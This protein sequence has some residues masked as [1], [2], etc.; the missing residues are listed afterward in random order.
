[1][2]LEIQ[3]G[4]AVTG[5]QRFNRPELQQRLMRLLLS[6]GGIKMFGLR[7]ISKSTLRLYVMEQLQQQGKSF[8]FIDA[9]GLHSIEDLIAELFHALPND[10]NLTTKVFKLIAD[11]SPIKKVME[12]LA[13]GTKTGDVMVAAYWKEAYNSIRDALKTCPV[14]PMLI[15]DEFPFLLKNMLN[16]NAEAKRD[17][18]NQL[19][20]AMREWRG[21]GMKMLLTG[22]IG[23]TALA[24]QYGLDRDH[25]NDLLPF[26]VPELTEAEARDFI[27]QATDYPDNQWTEAH[28]TEFIKQSS[29]LYPS[30]LVKG[31]LEIGVVNP[32]APEAFAEIFAC[33][34]RP[35]LHEDFYQQFNKRFKLY[36]EIDKTMQRHIVV[37]VLKQII[38]ASTAIQLGGLEYPEGY[39]SVELAE[40]LDMLVEDGFIRFIED[41]DGHR[42][43]LPASRLAK[44]WW[45]RARLA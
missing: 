5:A 1:M 35:V 38:G 15:I 4:N 36:G 14:P 11:D 37:P 34:V 32:S 3:Y 31:L 30:F 42:D 16:G 9:Q 13:K 27:R 28:I 10:L 18:V 12:A 23:I 20:A 2:V 45:Q 25:L 39:S 40:A 17:E 8:A 22:S 19:L 6:S 43:W 24:R 7:R 29:V 41:V 44:L 21:A 33:Y 26:E